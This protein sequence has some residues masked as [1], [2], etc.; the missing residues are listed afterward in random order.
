MVLELSLLTFL[1]M[2]IL[3]F[4]FHLYAICNLKFFI[5]SKDLQDDHF[6][7]VI[8]CNTDLFLIQDT[9]IIATDWG[10]FSPNDVYGTQIMHVQF[11]V[12]YMFSFKVPLNLIWF[13]VQ[14]VIY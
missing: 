6:F 1:K 4:N 11:N 5:N 14:I 3:I 12:T 13:I 7:N 10:C 9:V 2:L 8:Y